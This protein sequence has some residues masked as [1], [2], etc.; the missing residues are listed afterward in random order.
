MLRPTDDRDLQKLDIVQNCIGR[1][2]EAYAETDR[3]Q[4]HY[5]NKINGK[6][7][8]SEAHIILCKDK[9]MAEIYI[10]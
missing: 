10:N 4:S 1:L 5:I 7:S 8:L 6:N 2:T 9:E 3:R